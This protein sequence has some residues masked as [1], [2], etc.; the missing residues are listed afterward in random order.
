MQLSNVPKKTQLQVFSCAFL[1]NISGHF[2]YRT[3]LGLFLH[4]D[5]HGCFSII[6][7]KNVNEHFSSGFGLLK[8]ISLKV[9]RG[10]YTSVLRYLCER[11]FWISSYFKGRRRSI[12]QSN[13]DNAIHHVPEC[14]SAFALKIWQFVKFND[15]SKINS[16]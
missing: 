15:K 4:S 14:I 7:F 8:L 10:T 9:S 11:L 6:L 16:K 3:L 5:A 2:F 12:L 13:R 1:R